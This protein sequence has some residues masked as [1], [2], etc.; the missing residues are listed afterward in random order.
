MRC[1][2]FHH[3]LDLLLDERRDPASDVAVSAH[4]EHCT[5]CRDYLAAHSALLTGLAH[6]KS[7]ALSADFTERIVAMAAPQVALAPAP[8][9]SRRTTI[10]AAFVSA[11][12]M[13][14]A[15]SVLWY[16]RQQA[17]NDRIAGT[18]EKTILAGRGG[19]LTITRSPKVPARR[20]SSSADWQLTSADVLIHSPRLHHRFLA[21]PAMMG[22]V[23]FSLPEAARRIDEIERMA[24]G[25][26]PIR[27]SLAALWD[28]LRYAIPTP[29]ENQEVPPRGNTRLTVQHRLVA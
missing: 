14:L 6:I 1:P 18:D 15:V 5:A 27:A 13:L 3:R 12:V 24:P 21:Y 20:A 23:T 10:I 26:R 19:L 28:V 9:S 22:D 29:A 25:L 4:A 17:V 8:R 7:P 2:E 11:A 16:A